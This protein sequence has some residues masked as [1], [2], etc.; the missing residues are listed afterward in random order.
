MNPG[1]PIPQDQ[2]DQLCRSVERALNELEEKPEHVRYGAI[3][4]VPPWLSTI[5][6]TAIQVLGP[7]LIKALQDY[8]NS[9]NPQPSSKP[10][11]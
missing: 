4:G 10:G 3:A 2:H 7:A 6:Q 1:E 8:L 9:I 11:A 5:L